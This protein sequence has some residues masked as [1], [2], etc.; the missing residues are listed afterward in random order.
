MKQFNPLIDNPNVYVY[1]DNVY[2]KEFGYQEHNHDKAQ[3]VYAEGGIVHIYSEDRHWYLPARNYMWIPAGMSHSVVSQSAHLTIFNFYF[4]VEDGEADFYKHPN[5]YMVNDML[6]AMIHYTSGWS[7]AITE[8]QP[9]RMAFMKAVKAILPDIGRTITT[10]PVS[11]PYP[12]N[13]GLIKIAEYLSE[14]LET[15]FSLEEVARKF[16]YSSRTLSR[17]FK[18]DIGFSYVRFLRAIRITKA[19]EL[20]AENKYTVSEIA[21]AVGYTSLS[22]FSNIFDRIVGVR[23]SEFMARALGV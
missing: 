2:I 7:G 4:A 5:V 8:E 10:F 20:M 3:L 16:G 6:R 22:A 19:L 13:D 23:P 12:K 18:E 15:S 17:L 9:S 21:M 1:V 14:N 11:Y